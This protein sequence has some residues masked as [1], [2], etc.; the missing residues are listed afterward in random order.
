[1][2]LYLALSCSLR[3]RGK[4]SFLCGLA[5]NA[6]ILDVGC[7]NDSPY[8][9]KRVLP[10][11]NYTGIDIGDYHQTKPNLADSYIIARPEDFA[12]EIAKLSNNFDA[13]ISS[14]NLEHCSDRAGTL[15]AMLQSVK[16]GGVIYLSFPCEN[17]VNFPRRQG[18]LNYFDDLTHTDTPPNFNDVVSKLINSGFEVKFARKQYRPG[19]LWLFGIIVEPIAARKRKVLKGTWEYYGFES[20]IWARKAR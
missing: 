3:R 10:N 11:C 18:T 6:K 1:M 2:T 9:F 4:V 5:P 17:S 7:G 20:V 19:V 12:G 14:H 15:A 13:V 8:K 16:P